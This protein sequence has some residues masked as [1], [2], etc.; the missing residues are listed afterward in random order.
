MMAEG[1]GHLFIWFGRNKPLHIQSRMTDDIGAEFILDVLERL[2][3][4]QK[5]LSAPPVKREEERE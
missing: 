3:E 2:K 4:L 5:K 1:D